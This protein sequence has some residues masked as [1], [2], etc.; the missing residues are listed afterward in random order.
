MYDEQLHIE[1]IES[2]PPVECRKSFQ[3]DN[4]DNTSSWFFTYTQVNF[5]TFIDRSQSQWIVPQLHRV[6]ELLIRANIFCFVCSSISHTVSH[7]IHNGFLCKQGVELVQFCQAI[8]C[9]PSVREVER[10]I[11]AFWILENWEVCEV[12]L[13]RILSQPGKSKVNKGLQPIGL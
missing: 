7:D 6:M 1:S 11:M 5:G 8:K 12:K 2:S 9:F 3:W 10:A 13:L 4:F